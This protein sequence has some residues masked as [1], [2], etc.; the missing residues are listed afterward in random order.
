M[1]QIDKE[2]IITDMT[3][4]TGEEALKELIAAVCQVNPQIDRDTALA[5]LLEREQIGSTGV[6]NGI[7]F[8]HGV[9][10]NL[11]R[12]I[13]C[14]GRSKKGISFDAADNQPVYIFA[15]LCFPATVS[16]EYLKIMAWAS[17]FFRNKDN[18]ASVME[19]VNREEIFE[20]LKAGG[21]LTR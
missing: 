12:P 20:L 17:R 8:P 19:S 16:Y 13:L 2:C 14:F 18:L 7:A 10:P 5:V 3:S 1:I 11:E 15:G 9:V 21:A 4:T 6:G